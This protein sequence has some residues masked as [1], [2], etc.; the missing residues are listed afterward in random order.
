MAAQERAKGLCPECG[1]TISGRAVGPEDDH[2]DRRYVAL[3][4]HNRQQ[5]GRRPVACLTRGGRRVVERVLE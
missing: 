4:P 3:R 2:A 5:H 1:R